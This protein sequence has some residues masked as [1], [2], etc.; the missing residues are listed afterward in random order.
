MAQASPIDYQATVDALRCPQTYPDPPFDAVEMRDTHMSLLFFTPRHVFKMKKPVRYSFLDFSTLDKRRRDCE[1]EVHYNR[2]L[3]P[4]IYEG[5]A[6]LVANAEGQLRLGEPGTPVEWLVKM[7]RLP[8][9]RMLDS[10]LTREPVPEPTLRQIG[11]ILAR[12]YREQPPVLFSGGEYL[13]RLQ[14]NIDH[15]WR[16]LSDPAY[17]IDPVL[18][19]TVD[20]AQRD[21]I[22]LESPSLTER[23]RRGKIVEGHGDLRPE[24]VCLIDPPVIFDCLEFNRDFRI[25]DPVEELAYLAMECDLLQA[26][27]VG[28]ILLSAYEQENADNAPPRLVLFYKI[29]R[30]TLRARLSVLHLQDLHHNHWPK[31]R[32]QAHGYL[33]LAQTYAQQLA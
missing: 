19:Q 33:H 10:I 32:R 3:A 11:R 13:L 26:P 21:F 12:F 7:R 1:K 6:P 8:R 2:R 23:A 15:N 5:V 4:G 24:H 22:R 9:R 16:E 25:L 29:H 30:A 20:R 14:R 18:L 31:W 28:P 17:E 27:Q